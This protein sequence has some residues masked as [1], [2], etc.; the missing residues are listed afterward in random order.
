MG[1]VST[2]RGRSPAR[3]RSRARSPRSTSSSSSLSSCTNHPH[4]NWA[5]VGVGVGV[6]AWALACGVW[7]VAF[8]VGVACGVALLDVAFVGGR[9]FAPRELRPLH[10][11][12]RDVDPHHTKGE[13]LN[14][15]SREGVD[16]ERYG[17]CERGGMKDEVGVEGLEGREEELCL[18]SKARRA[19]M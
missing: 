12:S 15:V 11:H 8:G 1:V 19:K 18:G 2:T 3:L 13:V 6:W 7:R 5:H 9:S 4:A 10:H 16:L 17:V 14:V